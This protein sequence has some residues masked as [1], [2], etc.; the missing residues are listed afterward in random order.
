MKNPR[1]RPESVEPEPDIVE[2]TFKATLD[3]RYLLHLPQR[4]DERT[5]L[6]ATLHGFGSNPEVMLQLT[7]TMLEWKHAIASIQ[8]PS[9]FFLSPGTKDVGYCWITHK[10]PASSIRLHHDMVQ[11]VLEEAGREYGIPSER[12]MLVGFSQP[13]G[14]NYRFAATHPAS[15]R[16]VIGICG[17]LPGDWEE[18]R[19]QKISASLLHIARR[20]DEFY[21]PEI[22]EKYADRLRLRAADVEFA[23]MDGG[24]RFPSKAGPVVER[25]I[26]RVFDV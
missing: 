12:R 1:D 7:G 6:A 13:A 20:E 18:G 21:P 26:K 19:Y 10:Y 23:M 25:W 11:H 3:C 4:V 24:H 16:G 8:A 14:L 2:Q 15:V 5:L 22:T 17:G 9:E